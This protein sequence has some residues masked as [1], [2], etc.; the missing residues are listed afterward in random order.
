MSSTG[1]NDSFISSHLTSDHSAWLITISSD[2]QVVIDITD[3]FREQEVCLAHRKYQ[4]LLEI[5]LRRR[6][7][8]PHFLSASLSPP[9]R[10]DL[11]SLRSAF[12][13]QSPVKGVQSAKK[14]CYTGPL[15][16]SCQTDLTVWKAV[17]LSLTLAFT[18]S[19]GGSLPVTVLVADKI[20]FSHMKQ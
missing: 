3:E 13:T 15:R 4:F 2:V 9:P 12:Q 7:S 18:S 6:L 1:S 5:D 10:L 14:S 8:P 16:L 17:V 11:G 19:R 20:H